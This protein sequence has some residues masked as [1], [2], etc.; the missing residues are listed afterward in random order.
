MVH[1]LVSVL[2]QVVISL[3]KGLVSKL[4]VHQE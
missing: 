3:Y 1:D 4:T 2:K